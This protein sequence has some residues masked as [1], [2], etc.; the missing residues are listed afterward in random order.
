VLTGRGFRKGVGC[1]D[2]DHRQ[3]EM[4]AEQGECESNSKYMMTSCKKSCG[5]C[6]VEGC[7]DEDWHKCPLWARDGECRS[8]SRYMRDHC[9]KSCGVCGHETNKMEL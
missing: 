9:P 6:D 7:V 5:Y 1:F 3:C 8:N 4:W 2:N